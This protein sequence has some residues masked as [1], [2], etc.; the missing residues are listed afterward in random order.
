MSDQKL[1]QYEENAPKYAHHRALLLKI[2]SKCPGLTLQQIVTKELDWYGFTFTTDNRLR[3]LRNDKKL[4]VSI[5]GEDRL[6]R[7]YPKPE[8]GRL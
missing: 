3:E 6:L 7:W 8:E 2:I 5:E 4:I 1:S